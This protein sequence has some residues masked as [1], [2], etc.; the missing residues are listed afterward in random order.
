ML[1]RIFA[2]IGKICFD[3]PQLVI[4]EVNSFYDLAH[5]SEIDKILLHGMDVVVSKPVFS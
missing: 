1:M 5:Y 4:L 3:V 2:L